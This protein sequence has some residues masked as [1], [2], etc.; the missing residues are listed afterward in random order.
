[1]VGAGAL[2]VSQSFLI[3]VVVLNSESTIRK[4]QNSVSWYHITSQSFLIKV[5]V[6]NSKILAA[7]IIEAV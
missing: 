2:G 4:F 5:V 7:E 1:M 6:L 3:K